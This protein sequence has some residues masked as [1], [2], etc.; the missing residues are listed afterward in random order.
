MGY[1]V[2]KL[3]NK[4]SNPKWKI[5]YV[6]RKKEHTK[7]STAQH[8][9]RTWDITKDRYRSLGI[10]EAM[11]ID[12][13]KAVTKSLNAKSQ[14]KRHEEK[15]KFYEQVRVKQQLK[16]DAFLP[17]EFL[18][19]FEKRF[20]RWRIKRKENAKSKSCVVWNT[21]QKMICDISISPTDWFENTYE[22]YDWF[23]HRK[24]SIS[25][26]VKIIRIAN[27]WGFYISKKMN[28]SF[29][30]I[31]HPRG[32]E[33][34]RL[35]DAYY[36]SDRSRRMTSKPLFPKQLV[37]VK[38][39]MKPE[40]FNWLYIS[41]WLGLRP[42]EIDQLK[43]RNMWKIETLQ[44]GKK[45][46]WVYQTKICSLPPEDRWKLIPIQLEEQEFALRMIVSQVF[47]RP[48]VKTVKKYFG[49]SVG[50]YGGRKGFT[51]LMLEKGFRIEAISQWMGH[52]SIDRTWRTY[53]QR[54]GIK[55][56]L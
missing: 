21:A 56:S 55:F 2:K 32:Q 25:Y 54:Q 30:P 50:L 48:L 8:P 6:S 44:T 20:V 4:K 49:S 41:V 38:K 42:K 13:A 39:M 5:Q 3:A 16:N 17:A 52:M 29:L 51:D 37:E 53:K 35:I 9:T 33:R 40:H 23:Y 12:E 31:P 14:L 18:L 11:T 27:L 46:L 28:Q 15:I 45:I 1:Y 36:T 43:K 34:R 7:K 47:K 26:I 24:Y 19:E 10:S 22:I